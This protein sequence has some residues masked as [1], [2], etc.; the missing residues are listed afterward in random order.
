MCAL[1]AFPSP[2][3]AVILPSDG[4]NAVLRAMRSAGLGQK[5]LSFSLEEN[6]P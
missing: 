2:L 6:K 3:L 1:S 5:A 4:T